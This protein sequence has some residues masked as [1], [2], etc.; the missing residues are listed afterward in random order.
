MKVRMRGTMTHRTLVTVTAFVVAAAAV[1]FG[2]SPDD[3]KKPLE[4][5][6][7]SYDAGEYQKVLDAVGN[8]EDPHLMYLVAQTQQKLRKAD[9]TKKVYEKLSSRPDTDAWHAIGQSGIAML[10]S[11][12]EDA[13]KA[14]DQAITI[15]GSLAEAHYQRGLALSAREQMSDA[16]AAFQKATD[17]DPNWAYAHYYAGIAYSKVKRPDLT[18]SH[19]QN[20]LRLAP[21]A[22]ERGQVQSILRT[23]GK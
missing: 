20:F 21:K 2:Q 10:E 22:P 18:A 4:E 12:P 19:F 16:A 15:D 6:R 3:A 5:A 9:E 17:L 14:A 1:V 8:S 7:K 23:L 13:A 11:K